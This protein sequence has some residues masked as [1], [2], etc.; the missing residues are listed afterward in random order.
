MTNQGEECDPDARETK[1]ST[2][3]RWNT[4]E[5]SLACRNLIIV[6]KRLYDECGLVS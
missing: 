3:R 5:N 1:R 4:M 6:F 2:C